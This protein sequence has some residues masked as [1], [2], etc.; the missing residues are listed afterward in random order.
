[1]AIQFVNQISSLSV[2]TPVDMETGESLPTQTW[3]DKLW[4]TE[5]AEALSLDGLVLSWKA[6]H[7]YHRHQAYAVPAG[8]YVFTAN[9]SY[10][11]SVIAW[12]DPASPDYLCFDIILLNGVEEPMPAPKCN[13]DV[14]RLAWG[15]IGAGGTEM[16]LNVLRHVVEV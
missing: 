7:I 14:V 1:M 9:A 8:S 3:S 12:L 6:C 13:N 16:I 4:C 15:T 5:F 11:T 2:F 10:A